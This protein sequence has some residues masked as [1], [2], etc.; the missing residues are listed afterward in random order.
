MASDVLYTT[1]PNAFARMLRPQS[2]GAVNSGTARE[3]S[4]E[5]H[6]DQANSPW[7]IGNPKIRTRST[8]MIALHTPPVSSRDNQRMDGGEVDRGPVDSTGEGVRDL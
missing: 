6:R 2:G 4:P 8:L 3:C 1:N 7:K 5:D